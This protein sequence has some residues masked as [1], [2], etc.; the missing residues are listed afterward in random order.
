MW[1]V[2]LCMTPTADQQW[3]WLTFHL[4]I[5]PTAEQQWDWLTFRTAT[6][7][8]GVFSLLFRAL[9]RPLLLTQGFKWETNQ[10]SRTGCF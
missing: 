6:Y 8:N 10:I 7:V 4:C 5:T 1:H 2:H 9:G 3:D